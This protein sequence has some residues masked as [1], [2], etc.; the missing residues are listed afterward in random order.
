MFIQL[1]KWQKK[2]FEFFFLITEKQGTIPPT[3][4]ASKFIVAFPPIKYKP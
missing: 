3:L 4:E 2:H 1:D